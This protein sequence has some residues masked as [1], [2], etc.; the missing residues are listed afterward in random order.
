M[1]NTAAISRDKMAD[2]LRNKFKIDF[3][4]TTED[5]YGRAH[6]DDGGIWLSAEDVDTMPDG[7]PIFSYY[8]DNY[9]VYD[10]GVHVV[11]QG[12][13][14]SNGWMAE[15]HDAGTIMLYPEM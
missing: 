7:L 6:N 4:S 11:F 12:F 5:F 8:S 3:I 2:I 13:L 9:D 14:E 15:W 1:Q 10:M